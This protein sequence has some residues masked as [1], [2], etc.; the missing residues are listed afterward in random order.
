MGKPSIGILLQINLVAIKGKIG[1]FPTVCPNNFSVS[2]IIC[3]KSR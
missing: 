1:H 3:E 2:L